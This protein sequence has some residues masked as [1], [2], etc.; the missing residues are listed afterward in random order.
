MP[1]CRPGTV[2]GSSVFAPA[3]LMM[4]LAGCGDDGTP[5]GDGGGADTGGTDAGGIDAGGADA[6]G[7]D[8][9]SGDSGGSDS[10]GSDG[11]G[12]DAGGLPAAC[13][14]PAMITLSEADSEGSLLELRVASRPAFAAHLAIEQNPGWIGTSGAAPHE[15]RR[16]GIVDADGAHCAAAD[17][18]FTY[19][20]MHHDCG[21]TLTVVTPFGTY[22]LDNY[23]NVSRMGAGGFTATFT[24]AS[25]RTF[26]T[27]SAFHMC[28]WPIG[29]P[30][31]M[32]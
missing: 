6:G 15:I 19:V 28:E 16:V 5:P 20:T 9:G 32:M 3:L 27:D 29:A 24:V 11:G 31:P 18:D 12:A 8:S 10:G 23:G 26:G 1:T 7:S 2:F 22:V 14:D 13:T 21:N 30:C 4:A 17:T 25:C